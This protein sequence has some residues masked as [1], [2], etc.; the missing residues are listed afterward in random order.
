MTTIL[1]LIGIG[2]IVYGLSFLVKKI[3]QRKLFKNFTELKLHRAEIEEGLRVFEAML[4]GGQYLSNF[5]HQQWRAANEKFSSYLSLSF[6]NLVIVD[7]FKKSVIKFARYF[8]NARPDIDKH[9]IEVSRVESEH[10]KP[11]LEVRKIPFNSDQLT[12]A[13]SEEDNTLVVA[14][15]GTGKTTT[16]LGKLA[17]LIDRLHVAPADILLLSFTGKAVEEL[18]SRV[19]RHFPE[20]DI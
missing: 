16:I 13:V 18:Q 3:L 17:Y 2:A 14:G 4:S 6:E 11:L 1:I 8:N 19:K 12:A 9:N 15:A 20:V 5:Q 7:S 10:L